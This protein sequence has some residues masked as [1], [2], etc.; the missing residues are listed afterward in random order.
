MR[1]KTQL[2]HIHGKL[3][4]ARYRDEI[5]TPHMLPAMNLRRYV[6]LHDNTWSH[7]ARATVD[8]LVNHGVTVNLWLFKSLDLNPVEHLWMTWIDACASRQPAP[9]TLQE[10]QQALEQEWGRIPR[11]YSSIDRD[12]F[13]LCYRLMVSTTDIDILMNFKVWTTSI[14]QNCCPNDNY[15]F[16]ISKYCI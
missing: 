1:R 4:A 15:L 6:F 2:V 7:T 13:V 14:I 3:S 8:F 5:L 12:V 10:L 9:K 11:T 16:K